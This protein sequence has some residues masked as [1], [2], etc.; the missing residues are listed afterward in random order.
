MAAGG[1][2]SSRLTR[3]RDVL[4]RHVDSGQAPGAIVMLARHGEVVVEEVGAMAVDSAAGP[5][6]P[7][8]S[9][10]WAR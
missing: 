8:R 10:G 3:V 9:A 7:T 1:F 5:M 4:Q 2:S 6:A